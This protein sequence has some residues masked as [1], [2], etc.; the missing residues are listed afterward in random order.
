[1][2]TSMSDGCNTMEGRLGGVKVQL[3]NEVN[4]FIDM[5]SCVHHRTQRGGLTMRRQF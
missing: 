2:F 1:M 4:Q 5:G 3:Q